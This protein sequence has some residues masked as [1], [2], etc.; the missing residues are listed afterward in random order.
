MNHYTG[1]YRLAT[2]T[3]IPIAELTTSTTHPVKVGSVD[4]S[5][6][7]GRRARTANSRSRV[8]AS[9]PSSASLSFSGDRVRMLAPS[10]LPLSVTPYALANSSK[11]VPRTARI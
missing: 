10:Q 7:W 8:L 3:D 6:G 2:A 4:A 5:A 1:T 9:R 11:S